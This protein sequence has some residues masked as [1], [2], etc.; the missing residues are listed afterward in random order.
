MVV[1]DTAEQLQRHSQKATPTLVSG[2]PLDQA[3]EFQVE[4]LFS[5]YLQVDH[6]QGCVVR[7]VAM[8]TSDCATL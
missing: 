5:R 2:V 7:L 3:I 6:D 4:I 8:L 1:D